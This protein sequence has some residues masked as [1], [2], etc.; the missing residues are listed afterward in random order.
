MVKLVVVAAL[1]VMKERMICTELLKNW[2][3]EKS[4]KKKSN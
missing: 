1:F 4:I 3:D 2:M